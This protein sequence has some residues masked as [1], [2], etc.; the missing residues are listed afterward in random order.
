[1]GTTAPNP[2]IALLALVGF[3]GAGLLT[4][5][6]GGA[7]AAPAIAGWYNALRPA[8]GTPPAWV[9]PLVWPVI[10][11]LSGLAAWLV[12]RRPAARGALRLWYAQL[13]LN[14]LW[15][16]AFFGMHSPAAGLVVIV[17][18]LG[19]LA[20]CIRAFAP[21]R[22]AAGLMTFYIAWV[23]YATWLNAACFY[24]NQS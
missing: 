5:A 21:V 9:F 23:G 14:F 20:W 18:L 12:W 2:G 24:L 17:P 13:V 15:T 16:P 1:M 22:L 8:P 6:I 4:G 11:V 3:I 10:Y 19:V 7:I